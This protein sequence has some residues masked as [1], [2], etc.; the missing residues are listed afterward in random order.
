MNVVISRLPVKGMFLSSK[1]SFCPECENELKPGDLVP[2]F[3][4]V[5][6]RGRC[7]YCSEKISVRYPLVEVAGAFFAVVSFWR[8]GL[9]FATLLVFAIISVLLAIALI[10]LKTSEIPDSLILAISVCAVA[11]VWVFPDVGVIDRAIGFAV[12]SIPLLT[13]TLA[14]RG[15]FGGGDIKLMA[16]SG[17]LL[18]WQATL[19]AFFIA[20]VF[21]G[22]Y[23]IFL[24]IS[25][26]RK[27]GEHMVFG[28]AICLGV[29]VSLFFGNE[30]I[31]WYTGLFMIQ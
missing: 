3:G 15:A 18:G 24:I 22:G 21:G 7:R 26:R 29:A 19:L 10:D 9:D 31:Y 14:V 5:F 6:L 8:F 2:F 23:A 30:I 4:W 17:F 13:V 11:A 20:L 28:P 1:R 16:V 12:V 27:R 25:G